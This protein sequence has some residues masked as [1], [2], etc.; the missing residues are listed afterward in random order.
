MS[1]RPLLDRV[2]IR[3]DA[4]QTHSAGGIVLPGMATE[5]ANRGTVVAV[6][7]GMPR[8]NGTFQETVV[9]PGDRVLFGPY[10]GSSTVIH[11]G[12]KLLVLSESEI[13]AVV[14]D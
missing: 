5:Q 10:A 13:L 14:E 11:D 7:P 2:L 1:L 8:P 9:Q 12:E 4:D 6:G 3:R